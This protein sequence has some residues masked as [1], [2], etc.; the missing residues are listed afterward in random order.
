MPSIEAR[1]VDDNGNS[2]TFG[3]LRGGSSKSPVPDMATSRDA[4]GV[5]V[6]KRI[7]A[8]MKKELV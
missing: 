8:E 2:E 5:G 4:I 1:C 6:V 3:F 7:K